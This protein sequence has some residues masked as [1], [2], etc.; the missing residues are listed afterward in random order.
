MDDFSTFSTKSWSFMTKVVSCHPLM[1]N[2][3]PLRLKSY[4]FQEISGARLVISCHVG[5]EM[6][7]GTYPLLNIQITI[8]NH[9]V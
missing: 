6:G 7:Q 8:E 4:I 1:E 5:K 3:N 9:H 2:T